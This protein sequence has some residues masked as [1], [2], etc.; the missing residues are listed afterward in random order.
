MPLGL[1]R[2]TKF[3]NV[4]TVALQEGDSIVL[5]TDGLIEAMSSAGEQF[6]IKRVLS[7]VRSL[8]HR[9][10]PETCQALVSAVEEFCRPGAPHDDA[11]V[12]MAKVA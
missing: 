5:L 4:P 10:P 12:L 6:G 3:P 7:L 1:E 2:A 8:R 9:S 11:T